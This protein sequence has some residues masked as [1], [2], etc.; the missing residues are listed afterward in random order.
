MIDKAKGRIGL[1]LS[2]IVE[3]EGIATDILIVANHQTTNL[4]DAAAIDDAFGGK[5]PLSHRSPTDAQ[6]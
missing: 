6:A 1:E 3:V 5:Q 4:T 2:T